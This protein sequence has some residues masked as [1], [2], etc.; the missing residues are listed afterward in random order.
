MLEVIQS[1]KFRKDY[2]LLLKQGKD[3]SLLEEVIDLLIE[4]KQLPRKYKDHPLSRNWKGC[5]ECH[6]QGDWILI[7]KIDNNVL[8]LTLSRSGSH[9]RILHI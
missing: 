6:I 7:Y 9:S 3:M 8:T 1:S 5:R 4:E 2:E